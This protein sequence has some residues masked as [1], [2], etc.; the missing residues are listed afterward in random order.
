MREDLLKGVDRL[1]PIAS[2]LGISMT[3][4]ALAWVLRQPNLASAIIGASKPEQVLTN[5][6]ASGIKL[7]E[8]A[9]LAI[10]EA[11]EGHYRT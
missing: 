1:D 5:A 9:L 7:D 11:L 2:E 8:G 3:Q 6:S 10:D 4:L